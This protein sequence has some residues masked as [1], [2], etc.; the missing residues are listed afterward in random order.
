MGPYAG[1][2]RAAS[3]TEKPTLSSHARSS[4]SSASWGMKAL[5]RVD[6]T[7]S[8]RSRRPDRSIRYAIAQSTPRLSRKKGTACPGNRSLRG[9]SPACRYSRSQ[10][11]SVTLAVRWLELNGRVSGARSS[12]ST[13]SKCARSRATSSP[14]ASDSRS[15]RGTSRGWRGRASAITSIPAAGGINTGQRIGAPGGGVCRRRSTGRSRDR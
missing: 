7:R 8:T 9:N 6:A 10:P 1:C 2:T 11:M 3:A 12:A 5:F 15:V 13:E 14:R 4:G